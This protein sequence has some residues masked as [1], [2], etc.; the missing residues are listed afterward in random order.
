MKCIL[1]QTTIIIQPNP[2]CILSH[3]AEALQCRYYCLTD[4]K[5]EPPPP[6]VHDGVEEYQV[7]CILDSWIFRGKLKYLV[8]WKGYSIKEDEWRP[9][10]DVKGTTR[11][12]SEFYRQNP[13][14]PQHISAVN[15][16]KLPFHTL[17]NF[18]DTSDTVPS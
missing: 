18:T 11:L 5:C 6:V 12:V 15:F 16:S 1:A 7:E 14:A 17:T 13:K 8:W 3:P 4:K 9:S 2:P 10:K